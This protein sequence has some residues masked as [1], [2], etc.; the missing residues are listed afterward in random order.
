MPDRSFTISATRDFPYYRRVWKKVVVIL[1]A[2]AFLPFVVIGGGMYVYMAR[3]IKHKTIEVLETQVVSHKKGIDSFLTE[4]TMDLKLIS[5]NNR[6][7]EMRVPG[8]IEQVLSLLQNELP[9]FQDLGI[10]GQDGEHLAYTG[11][12]D[13]TAKNYSGSPWFKAVMAQGIYV[14]DV[15]SG[16]RNDPHFIIAV[17]RNEGKNVWVLRAT[18]MS[19]MFDNLVTRVTGNRKGDAFLINGKGEYQTNP[20]NGGKLMMK[21]QVSPPGHFPGVQIEQNGSAITLTTW[22]ETIPWLSV[23]SI[24]KKDI[25]EELR[26]VRNISVFVVLL[27]GFIIILSILFTTDSL[28]SMLEEKKKNKLCLDSRLTRTAFLASAMK[29]S[30]GVFSD[31]NDILSNIHITATLMKE[32]A[33]AQNPGE[34]NFLAEQIFSESIRGKNLIDGFIR[35]IA[36][37]DP[38]IMDVDI[39]MILNRILF[40][41]KTPLIEK[42]IGISTDFYDEM[43]FVRSDVAALHQVFLNLMLNASAVIGSNGSI[44]ISTSMIK[45]YARI[46]VSD[47]GSGLGNS[48]MERIF[49]VQHLTKRGDWG[50]GLAISRFTMEKIGGGIFV[51]NKGKQGVVFEVQ[52]PKAFVGKFLDLESV[53]SG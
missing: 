16:F 45:N 10:I 24:D 25:F 37:K 53:V 26:Q 36:P 29:L 20:R 46:L 33:G 21:S 41:L 22:L 19:D 3:T 2:S 47:N 40:F 39:H 23:V 42:N 15:F 48:D 7:A 11:P 32:R 27:S 43:P 13:L 14:S 30:K 49:D 9:C 28:V 35:F 1:M 17:K 50:F 6:L 51:K 8:A 52:V 12:Y 5:E 34:T 4:R 44:T 18:V 31:M 38:V